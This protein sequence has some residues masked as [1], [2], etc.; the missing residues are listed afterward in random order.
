MSSYYQRYHADIHGRY[1]TFMASQQ[2]LE[3][4]ARGAI[5]AEVTAELHSDTHE[6]QP[7]QR[8][9]GEGPQAHQDFE[10]YLRQGPS[11]TYRRVSEARCRA[12]SLVR[13]HAKRFDWRERARAW[14][15]FHDRD[16]EQERK[17]ARREF[18]QRQEE[19]AYQLWRLGLALVYRFVQRDPDTGEWKIDPKLAP[20]DALALLKFVSDLLAQ[21]HQQPNGGDERDTQLALSWDA[22]GTAAEGAMGSAPAQPSIT[23]PGVRRL[24][25]LISPD[26]DSDVPS[27]QPEGEAE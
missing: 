16:L 6:Q 7:W 25:G 13:K 26:S 4:P 9:A 8:L 17:T 14:D 1:T 10:E 11:R 23:H 5:G 18:A 19:E 21:I 3:Q 22:S 15:N 2:V 24:L 20:K 27:A 12:Y